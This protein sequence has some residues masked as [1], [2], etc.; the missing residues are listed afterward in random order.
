MKKLLIAALALT[1]FSTLAA[2]HTI[3]GGYARTDASL[4][5]SSEGLNGLNL[6][7]AFQPEE[8]KVGLIVSLTGT[9][10]EENGSGYHGELNYGSFM[11]G[12]TY[13]VSDWFKPYLMVGVAKGEVKYSDYYYDLDTSKTSPAFGL[14]IQFGVTDHF[15]ID[16]SYEHA[17]F[18]DVKANT[19]IIGAGYR[20]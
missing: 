5:G 2:E 1:S 6:K 19:F 14:G 16:T 9:T 18:D 7:Y 12:V 4:Y 11:G 17:S 3:T 10:Y 20:F 13:A 15:T 8:S